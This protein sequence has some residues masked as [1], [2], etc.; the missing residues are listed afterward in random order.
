MARKAVSCQKEAE[1]AGDKVTKARSVITRAAPPAVGP[2]SQGTV[3]GGL[4]FTAGQAA[5][6]SETGKPLGG[7]VYEQTRTI[8]ANLENILGAAGTTPHRIVKTTVYLKEMAFFQEMNRAYG[9]Y[10]E[11]LEAP[12]PARTTVGG[13][14]PLG[15]DV[16]VEAI[17]LL[18]DH[19]EAGGG[20]LPA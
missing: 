20:V 8:L 13:V 6:D 15:L 1:P 7:S 10:F 12:F 9:E 16:V 19:E 17:A 11:H 14:L 5:L 18:P 3:A 2:Y 4:V